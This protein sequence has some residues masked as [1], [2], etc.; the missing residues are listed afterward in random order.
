M[1]RPSDGINC[2]RSARFS[3]AADAPSGS[4]LSRLSMR[5]SDALQR[6]H[7]TGAAPHSQE[8]AD[9][10]GSQGS[11]LKAIEGVLLCF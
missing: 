11:W 2:C 8:C 7:I 6:L 3:K 10:S 5:L 9:N 1:L 4:L